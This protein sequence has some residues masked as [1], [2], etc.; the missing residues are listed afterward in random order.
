MEPYYQLALASERTSA[1]AA[2]RARALAS[3][4]SIRC[5]AATNAA[6]C[7]RSSGDFLRHRTAKQTM[8]PTVSKKTI[9]AVTMIV[10]NVSTGSNPFYEFVFDAEDV[11]F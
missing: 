10:R 9:K 4:E 5:S 11:V 7:D 1:A 3:T 6:D 8:Q 2:M